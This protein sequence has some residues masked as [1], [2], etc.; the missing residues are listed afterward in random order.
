[1]TV[2]YFNWQA[3]LQP[4]APYTAL[5]PN[6]AAV[7]DELGKR[8]GG[9]SL[10]GYGLRPI[11]GGEAWSTHSFGAAKDWRIP[12]H[13]DRAAAMAFL[14]EHY[15][16]LGIQAIHDYYGCRIWHANRYPGQ[17]ATSW[18]RAQKKSAT[19]G[20]GQTWAVYL[21]IETDRTNWHNSIPVANRAGIAEVPDPTLPAFVPE[22]GIWG[23]W[24]LDPKKPTIRQAD[25]LT[26]IPDRTHEAVRYLQGVLVRK[27]SQKLKI[28]GDPGPATMD[29]VGAF[30]RYVGL[31]DDEVVGPKTWAMIDK[32]AMR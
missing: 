32:V 23:L 6:V 29:A 8:F 26:P 24:P 17:P 9:T 25:G 27:A 1:M 11:R 30:Q 16:T 12:D 2:T 7:C 4:G 28:D 5:S 18:W 10:G 31:D 15:D 22:C 13:E 3:G 20:M 21:H 19:T 14:V